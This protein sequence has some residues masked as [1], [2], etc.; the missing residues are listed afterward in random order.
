MKYSKLGRPVKVI[1]VVCL[2]CISTSCH[3]TID[4]VWESEDEGMIASISEPYFI[5][6]HDFYKRIATTDS[7]LILQNFICHDTSIVKYTF[8]DDAL[9]L[10]PDKGLTFDSPKELHK[11]PQNMA[12]W[13]DY[14][15]D[16]AKLPN[17]WYEKGSKWILILDS[18]NSHKAY[19]YMRDDPP[20]CGAYYRLFDMD[21][22]N[23]FMSSGACRD[24]T[25]FQVVHLDDSTLVC[26]ILSDTLT[27][28]KMVF[29]ESEYKSYLNKVSEAERSEK[30]DEEILGRFP[31]R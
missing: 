16:I 15:L 7:S 25:S 21:R 26:L 5:L 9:I 11:R 27:F 17:C 22:N 8:E 13:A 18:I 2:I 6:N 1:L 29:S 14:K 31:I 20:F 30:E 23:L 28:S 24:I 4:G 3:K 19:S 10:T 12:E